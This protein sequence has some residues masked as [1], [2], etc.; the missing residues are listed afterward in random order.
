[1]ETIKNGII[2][3][4]GF[5]LTK[6]S[7]VFGRRGGRQENYYQ[8]RG[9]LAFGLYSIIMWFEKITYFCGII[10]IRNCVNRRI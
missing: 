9:I 1:M 2:S 7:A 4:P 10:K 5:G 8:N 6:F 3:G